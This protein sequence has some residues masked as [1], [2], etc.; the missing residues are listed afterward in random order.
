MRSALAAGMPAR[1][2]AMR[3]SSRPAERT[4]IAPKTTKPTVSP[5]TS[6]RRCPCRFTPPR[7]TPTTRQAS[8]IDAGAD[9]PLEVGLDPGFEGLKRG[10]RMRDDERRLL[11]A[12]STCAAIAMTSSTACRGGPCNRRAA[13]AEMQRSA[14]ALVTPVVSAGHFFACSGRQKSDPPIDQP[15]HPRMAADPLLT[16]WRK[17]NTEMIS[18]ASAA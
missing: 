16:C 4:A 18:T 12:G 1:T 9:G 8:A 10:G 11:S 14:L 3:L 7:S 6:Q 13:G 17:L 5:M 15:L 2:F